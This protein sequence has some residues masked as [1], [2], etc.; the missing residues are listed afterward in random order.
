MADDGLE[1]VLDENDL[2]T[3]A[4][5]KMCLVGNSTQLTNLLTTYG[6]QLVF[7]T[8]TGGVFTADNYYIRN[9]AN[10]A[11]L[12][13]VDITVATQSAEFTNT[14][15]GTSSE[16]LIVATHRKYFRMIMPST[17]EFFHIYKIEWFNGATIVG[18]IMCGIDLLDADPPVINSSVL[19]GNTDEVVQSG[20]NSAQSTTLQTFNPV[21][22]GAIIGLWIS[23]SSGTATIKGVGADRGKSVSYTSTPPSENGSAWNTVGAISNTPYLKIWYRGYA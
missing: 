3:K 17:Y 5:R 16:F 20:A 10:S 22:G 1:Y 4:N 14:P 11:W 9:S 21:R 8:T 19:L 6:G 23:G 15:V 7:A 12:T 13:G 18:N 2:H